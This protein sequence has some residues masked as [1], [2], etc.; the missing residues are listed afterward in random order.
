M[1]R[2]VEARVSSVVLVVAGAHL[3]VETRS[4]AFAF[5]FVFCSTESYRAHN[6]FTSFVRF[7]FHSVQLETRPQAAN[8]ARN[9]PSGVNEGAHRRP[10]AK[11]AAKAAVKAAWM[12]AG[13]DW[14]S[15]ASSE[16][17]SLEASERMKIQ[18][19]GHFEI[20]LKAELATSKRANSRSRL[21]DAR[22]LPRAAHEVVTPA[23]AGG[24]GPG[25]GGRRRKVLEPRRKKVDGRGR[26]GA[27]DDG[28]A[29]EA[30]ASATSAVADSSDGGRSGGGGG[31]AG[32]AE[33]VPA[34]PPTV[35]SVPGESFWS[36]FR[37]ARQARTRT[38]VAVHAVG[39]DLSIGPRRPAVAPA[40]SKV[41]D[42]AA[43]TYAQQRNAAQGDASGKGKARKRARVT[44][45]RAEER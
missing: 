9:I 17:V 16:L 41:T 22:A 25:K 6:S 28:S 19:K 14:A 15:Q 30:A 31:M 35:V 23:T 29:D 36:D 27:C 33:T 44:R 24:R 13:K 7:C 45:L 37:R 3:T 5:I 4:S 39:A 21:V 34:L 32:G 40:L 38:G 43:T 20:M 42:K 11:N 1:R 12:A 18:M 26:R 8:L 2:L 10:K